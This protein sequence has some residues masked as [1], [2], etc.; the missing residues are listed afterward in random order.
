MKLSKIIKAK[1]SNLMKI[2]NQMKGL[3]RQELIRRIEILQEDSFKLYNIVSE[4]TDTS[5]SD[6]KFKTSID[7]IINRIAIT[8]AID[9]N[10]TI[11]DQ[12]GYCVETEW[13][14]QKEQD[15]KDKLHSI[16]QDLKDI[17]ADK[18]SIKYIQELINQ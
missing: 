7:T 10:G 15:Q 6:N 12:D 4:N 8:T 11:T 17:N 9:N 5:C 3:S 14:T 18:K 1:G 13:L 16:A 2:K